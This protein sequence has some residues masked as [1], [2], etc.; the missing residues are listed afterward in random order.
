MKDVK[1]MSADQEL[2][3]TGASG[4]VPLVLAGIMMIAG[5]VVALWRRVAIGAATTN[6]GE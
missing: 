5:G 2:A 6:S 1:A 3:A 4:I